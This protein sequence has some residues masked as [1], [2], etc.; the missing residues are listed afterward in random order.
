MVNLHTKFE[1]STF[2]HALEDMKGNAKCRIWGGLDGG[3]RGDPRS[4]A[5]SP[6]NRAPMTYRYYS[7]LME[8]VRL[9][10]TVSTYSQL[11]VES[12]LF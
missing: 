3:V 11:F 1:V 8:T 4:P 9:S 10:C 5:M 12:R 2:I 7:P 6:I